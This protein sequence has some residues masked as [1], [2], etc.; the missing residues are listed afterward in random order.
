MLFRSKSI[1]LY[2]I[3]QKSTDS[4]IRDV[5]EAINGMSVIKALSKGNYENDKFDH[6]NSEVTKNEKKASTT[7]AL[8]NPF[9]NL[10]LNIGLIL[11]IVVGAWRVNAGLTQ[12]GKILAFLTYFTIILN[13]M[14]SISR[15]FILFSKAAASADR[16]MEVIN[17]NDLD[18]DSSLNNNIERKSVVLGKSVQVSHLIGCGPFYYILKI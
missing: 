14:L 15:M 18:I 6:Y 8:I 11:V 1:P 16:I 13:A 2:T 12:V 10:L 9:M 5:R 7:M 17:C 4:F 3:L